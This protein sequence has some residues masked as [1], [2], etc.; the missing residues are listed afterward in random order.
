LFCKF[1][2]NSVFT[3]KTFIGQKQRFTSMHGIAYAIIKI[4]VNGYFCS[5]VHSNYWL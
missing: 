4:T 5:N 1:F 2:D 3:H